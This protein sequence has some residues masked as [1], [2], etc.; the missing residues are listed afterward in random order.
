MCPGV[1]LALC[2]RSRPICTWPHFQTKTVPPD[3]ASCHET[4]KVK[5]W[6]RTHCCSIS[7][8]VSKAHTGLRFEGKA[9]ITEVLFQNSDNSKMKTSR[10][11]FDNWFSFSGHCIPDAESLLANHQWPL[12]HSATDELYSLF[13]HN[14]VPFPVTVTTILLSCL[15]WL[16]HFNL[17]SCFNIGH[18][19]VYVGMTLVS[20]AMPAGSASKTW[21]VPRGPAFLI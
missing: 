3:A 18:D 2:C 21:A 4:T 9:E 6:R 15:S 20:Q 16:L 5:D 13:P 1:H 17:H 8:Y 14:I 7:K 10:S 11:P 12:L 19:E